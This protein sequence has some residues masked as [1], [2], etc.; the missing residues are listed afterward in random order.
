VHHL[1]QGVVRRD[2]RRHRLAIEEIVLVAVMG[3]HAGKF[4]IPGRTS[5]RGL[6][7]KAAGG[8]A[9]SALSPAATMSRP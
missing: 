7:I 4:V 8:K 3:V 1:Q 2:C 6:G 5:S 9:T